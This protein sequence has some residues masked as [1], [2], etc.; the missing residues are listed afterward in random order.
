MEWMAE[1]TD[2]D[3]VVQLFPNPDTYDGL[4]CQCGSA[5]FN[6][7]AVT[8]RQDGSVSGYT[9]PLRCNECG[10]GQ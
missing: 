10:M 5:W 2:E 7:D 9:M 3:N 1:M 8:L 4:V 6:V